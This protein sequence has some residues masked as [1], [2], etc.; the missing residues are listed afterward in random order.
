MN[1]IVSF[2]GH[3]DSG[4]TRL[5]EK[6]VSILRNQGYR[7][8]VLK[9]TH[10]KI[11]I[12]R[13]GTDTDRLRRAGAEVSAIVDDRMLARFER[14]GEPAALLGS[15]ASEVDLLLV[16][17]YKKLPLPK[18]LITNSGSPSNLKGIAATYGKKP[19]AAGA[20]KARHFNPGQTRQLAEWLI[21]SFS[22]KGRGPRIRLTV[23]GRPLGLKP[24]VAETMA[25]V[26]AGLVRPLKGGRGR[27][28]AV[29]IDFGGKI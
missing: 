11:K 26:V 27:K 16:E 15:L 9:H 13:R 29:S 28:V 7:V 14:A 17:G 19:P 12:D 18:V 3:S 22:E 25:G 2:V 23:D 1:N 10:A 20:G 5:I 24:F 4:K 21:E 6:I 8:S